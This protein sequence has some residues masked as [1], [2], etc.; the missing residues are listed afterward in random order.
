MIAKVWFILWSQTL[1]P[2]FRR[3]SRWDHQVII[4][5]YNQGGKAGCVFFSLKDA[6]DTPCTWSE[7]EELDD[8]DA[9]TGLKWYLPLNPGDDACAACPPGMT[10]DGLN[11]YKITATTTTTTT[12]TTTMQESCSSNQYKRGRWFAA[13]SFN[14]PRNDRL[15]G[16]LFHDTWPATDNCRL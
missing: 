4:Q 9:H 13:S 3:P 15:L 6:T 12:T 10:C 16:E 8:G 14:C 2:P 1:N 7:I 5:Q 11:F